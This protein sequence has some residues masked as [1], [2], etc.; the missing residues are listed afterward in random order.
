MTVLAS[1]VVVTVSH[2]ANRAGDFFLACEDFFENVWP[3]PACAFFFFLGGAVE[4]SS[5]TLIPLF[6]PGSV[7][8]GSA[9]RDDCGRMFPGIPP[10]MFTDST[11]PILQQY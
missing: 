2:T 8:S 9:S 11:V 1:A 5:C 3:F 4:I 7:H 10:I 6:R